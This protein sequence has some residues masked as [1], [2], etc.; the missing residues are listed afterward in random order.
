[1]TV[2]YVDT[3]GDEIT[4]TRRIE[5]NNKT[6]LEWNEALPDWVSFV[7]YVIGA[8]PSYWSSLWMRGG[9][10]TQDQSMASVGLEFEPR[11]GNVQVDVASVRLTEGP[12]RAWPES[13]QERF[14]PV[15]MSTGYTDRN[16]VTREHRSGSYHRFRVGTYG[17]RD[18]FGLSAF[19]ID[20]T[21]SRGG[22]K[23]TR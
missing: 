22:H 21:P 18:P 4:A 12:D 14:D 5:R 15:P 23:T 6:R 2:V 11:A 17:I 13:I 16:L 20:L 8:I 1:M 7:S 10:I 19:K 9:P 3:N